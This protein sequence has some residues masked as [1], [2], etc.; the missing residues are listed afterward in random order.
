MSKIFVGNITAE[1][2]RLLNKYLNK[3]MPDAIVEPLKAAGI[4]GKIK[5]HARRPEVVLVILDETLYDMCK[6]VADDVLSL[7]KVHRYVNDTGLQSFLIE[8]FGVLDDIPAIKSEEV[9][10]PVVHIEEQIESVDVPSI[11]VELESKQQDVAEVIDDEFESLTVTDDEDTSNDSDKDSVIQKLN[12]ELIIR[13][14]MIRNLE[15][16]IEEKS[17]SENVAHF[18]TRIKSLESELESTKEELSKMQNDSY[19]DLGKVTRAEQILTSMD[20]LKEDLRVEK[21]KCLRLESSKNELE[22]QI[23]QKEEEL[24]RLNQSIEEL[25]STSRDCGDLEAKVAEL[26]ETISNL[27]SDYD[28]KV[29]EIE[30]LVSKNNELDQRVIELTSQVAELDVLNEKIDSLTEENKQLIANTSELTTVKVELENLRVDYNKVSSEKSALDE[31]IT[32]L[33]SKLE[34]THSNI[35]SVTL[36]KEKL[37]REIQGLTVDNESLSKQLNEIS[38]KLSTK[39][40]EIESLRKQLNEVSGVSSELEDSKARIIELQEEVAELTIQLKQFEDTKASLSDKISEV[41]SLQEQLNE[42]SSLEE[43]LLTKEQELTDIKIELVSKTE[44]LNSLINE[45]N[46]QSS[47]V[48]EKDTELESKRLEVSELSSKVEALTSQVEELSTEKANLDTDNQKLKNEVEVLRQKSSNSDT[49]L[50]TSSEL[51]KEMTECKRKLARLQSE[52]ESLKE[53]L[54]KTRGTSNKDVEIAKLRSEIS[55]YKEK[56]RVI[57]DS[58][59]EQSKSMSD[60]VSQ[61]RERCAS[62]EVSLLEREEKIKTSED[63]IFSKMG[64]IASPKTVFNLSLN[65]P[66]ELPNM[67]VFASGSSESN[68][69]TYQTLRRFCASTNK[70]VLILDLVTDSYI[71]REFGVEKILSPIEFLQGTRSINDFVSKAKVGNTYVSSTAFSYLNSLYLLN[72]DWQSVLAN[73]AGLTDIVIINVGCLNEIVSKVLFNAFSSVMQSH[74]IIKASPINLRTALLTLTGIPSAKTSKISCVNFENSSKAM[75]QRL[76]QKF[77]TQILKDSDV[78]K[79]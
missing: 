50:Q 69:I 15:A 10:I 46:S 38:D 79:L 59:N 74:I 70:S 48:E 42:K 71:D 21:D 18:V 40:D 13:D 75:Y 26:E 49:L 68:L 20:T 76:A 6:G 60:E 2:E 23:K 43:T 72:V 12:D 55:D 32:E 35:D 45:R 30:E 25:T 67:Y 62:L 11:D 37:E 53:D 31:K 61:L 4:K 27:Q 47:L 66:K 57:E 56:L 19:A 58:N 78:L 63:S 14:M 24:Q 22:T 51:E 65:V 77:N 33:K 44:E 7:P 17:A 16:Q 34:S 64:T 9:E 73:L 54:E 3:F 52:N 29:K 41:E 1:A 28:L 5:N 36:D 39:D 8:K